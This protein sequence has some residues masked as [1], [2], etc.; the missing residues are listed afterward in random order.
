MAQSAPPTSDQDVI[1]DQE[2]TQM[3]S[4]GLTVEDARQIAHALRFLS[5]DAVQRANSGHPGAPMGLADVAT[6]IWQKLNFD[7]R[8]PKWSGRDRFVLSCGHASMLLYSLL[9]VWGISLKRGDLEQFRQLNSLT[10]GHPEV[11]HTPGVEMTTGPLGQ[12]CATT[13][14]L[15]LAAERLS[16]KMSAS[17]GGLDH[18]WARQKTVAL[19]SDGD[20]MEGISYEAA[21]L[22]G[23]WQL[24]HLIWFYDDN[25]ISID[26]E[27]SLSF[28]ED[29]AS[30]FLAM[31]WRIFK[32]D[33]HNPE[34]LCDVVDQSWESDGRPTLVICRTHIG[35]GSPNKVDRSASHGAPL[36]EGEIQLT[37]EALGWTS[38]PFS[39]PQKIRSLMKHQR[40]TKIDRVQSWH[41]RY[42][43]WSSQAPQAAETA[44]RLF[45]QDEFDFEALAQHLIGATKSAGATR[46]LSNQA[47]AQAMKLSPRL[48]GGSAD[49]SGSNGL[50]FDEPSFGS[51]WR[52]KSLSPH[53][54]VIHFGVREHAMAAITN[55]VTLHGS[56]RGFSGT[57]LVFSDYLRPALRLASLSRIPSVYVLTHD[58]VF[59]GEDGPTHQPVEHA[60]ALRLI[61]G[62][63]DFRPASG[64]EV[65][66]AWAWSLTEASGP[67]AMMLTRQGLPDLPGGEALTA[68]DISRGA[69]V[70]KSYLPDE[71]EEL[72]DALED[73]S[74]DVA[75]DEALSE[76]HHASF[77]E[78]LD[79]SLDESL[80]EV[81]LDELFDMSAFMLT[82]IG[83]GSEVALCVQVAEQLVQA[84]VAVRVVSM[85]S[86]NRFLAQPKSWREALLGAG[87]R[88]SIEA[89][90]TLPW[91]GV[92]GPDS[93]SIGID[94]FGASAPIH[95]L[96]AHF[97]L[98]PE[99]VTSRI[100]EWLDDDTY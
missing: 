11:G 91:H 88:V 6:A 100:M 97:H 60:W 15:A 73:R 16:R 59:L 2:T 38:K 1:V 21:S 4:S 98:T 40:Q 35:Y 61:P 81:L 63:T 26:G 94:T 46:K 19:C 52:H 9:H 32:V 80:D 14:G 74:D 90:S 77:E 49:L 34:A 43:S 24:G 66:S 92:I 33:G 37:R 50:S 8:D 27:T 53:G 5:I 82:L 71:G 47:L 65:A 87:P 28:S 3:M 89:G 95:D 54:R 30:R 62:V 44:A 64:I 67:V 29:V 45:D 25:R 58:S 57:F 39:V 41:E 55:G 70:L 72:G 79:E 10:P 18:P 23:H 56:A 31:G 78:L 7:P 17:G 20:L 36:G 84:G 68:D 12:G 96:V 13:V 85:P 93:L 99:Q 83:T 86:V 48:L 42:E 51:P 69:Y 22:A 76:A 75:E